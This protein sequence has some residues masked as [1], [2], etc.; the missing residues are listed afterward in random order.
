MCCKDECPE[1]TLIPSES[2][3]LYAFCPKNVYAFSAKLYKGRIALKFTLQSRQLRSSHIDDHYCAAIFKY[4][5]NIAVKYRENVTFLSIDDKSKVDFGEPNLAI[6]AGVR[7]KKSI[8]PLT[9]VLGALDHDV[10]SKGSLTLSVCL[11]VD[12]PEEMGTFYQGQ[13]TVI[14]KDAVFQPSTQFR[15]STELCQILEKAGPVNPILMIYSD[16]GPHHRFTFSGV[17]LSLIGLFK[18]LDLDLLVVGRTAPGHSWA[19]PVERIMSLLNLA[20][21]NVAQSRSF[22]TAEVEQ[23]LKCCGGMDDIRKVG[24]NNPEVEKQWLNFVKSMIDKLN[25]RTRRVILKGK[26]FDTLEPATTKEINDLQTDTIHTIDAC[27]EIGK[28]QKKDLHNKRKFQQF[29]E[30]HCILRNYIFQV[31]KCNDRSCCPPLRN[32]LGEQYPWLPD[33]ILDQ[34][35]EHFLNLD[36]LIGKK[37]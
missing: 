2:T 18:K 9:T 19:N 12:V 7:G 21:Q 1:G 30:T 22:C 5:R 15:H 11:N 6:S 4:M 27:I 35:K 36:E 23:I 28:Y 31:R 29:L 24:K 25:E 33:P 34:E 3:V 20:Y 17:Q 13:V 14:L 16:G 26:L 32:L 37:N 8:V 10:Q